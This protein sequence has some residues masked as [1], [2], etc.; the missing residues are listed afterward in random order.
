MARD[1][2]LLTC[3]ELHKDQV[4]VS[5][6]VVNQ[7][8]LGDFTSLSIDDAATTQK[9]EGVLDVVCRPT[10]TIHYSGARPRSV[11]NG[12]TGGSI[13]SGQVAGRVA[14]PSF[15]HGFSGILS[16]RSTLMNCATS[17]KSLTLMYLSCNCRYFLM[18]YAT[19]TGPGL[20]VGGF[21]CQVTGVSNLLN[22]SQ[23]LLPEGYRKSCAP[24]TPLVHR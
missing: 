8:V 6:V 10:S 18:K 19:I 15:H 21:S 1:A 17:L 11:G 14:P 4:A 7:L 3:Q 16:S 12:T 13:L 23:M 22:F 9:G 20:L 5:H 24:P 2:A